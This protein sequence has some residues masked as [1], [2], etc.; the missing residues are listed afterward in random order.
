MCA[1]QRA[2][3]DSLFFVVTQICGACG[4]L[5]PTLL[6][7]NRQNMAIFIAFSLLS[8]SL[9]FDSPKLVFAIEAE[10]GSSFQGFFRLVVMF[11]FN[12][13]NNHINCLVIEIYCTDQCCTY[14]ET[15]NGSPGR[16]H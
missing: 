12:D 5:T 1:A 11:F 8:R 14:H 16:Q 13:H 4:G 15:T 2:R 9:L 7:A 10:E 6:F 3:L